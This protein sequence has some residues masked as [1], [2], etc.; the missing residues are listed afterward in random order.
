MKIGI[1]GTGVIGTL[2]GWAL[3]EKNEVIHI[4]RNEKREIYNGRVFRMDVIDERIEG[5]NQNI[6]SQYTINAESKADNS[7][8]LL[9]VP[10]AEQ[11]LVQD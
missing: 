1:L 9:I 3:S 2:Y 10:V 8:D 5:D 6:I 4:V 11:Q 7:F